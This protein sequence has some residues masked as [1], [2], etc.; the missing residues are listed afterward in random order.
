MATKRAVG[1]VGVRELEEQT[2]DVLR[3]VRDGGETIDVI[4]RGVV[5]ARIVPSPPPVDPETLKHIWERRHRLAEEISRHW[6]E[7]VSAADAVAEGRREL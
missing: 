7:G 1:A 4:D 6:P 3:R 2:R 5:I